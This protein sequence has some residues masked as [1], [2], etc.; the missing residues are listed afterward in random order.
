[1]GLRVLH[2]IAAVAP[3]YGGP[4]TAVVGMCR[5]LRGVGVETLV[6]TT[7]ADGSDRLPVP[8][9]TVIAFG[10]VPAIFFRRQWSEALKYSRPL[11]RWLEGHV[12]AFD[13]VHVHGVF[14]HACLAAARSAARRGIPY[15]VRP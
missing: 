12:G 3:R 4:S 8:L 7:D 2:V 14:S 13:L 6:A 11:G 1:M 5:A 9:G 10:G 15:L